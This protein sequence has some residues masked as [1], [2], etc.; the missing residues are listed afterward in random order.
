M[1]IPDR[2]DRR[3]AMRLTARASGAAVLGAGLPGL[4]AAC[5][6][7]IK[8]A[9]RT[10]Y[11]LEYADVD[12]AVAGPPLGDLLRLVTARAK[13]KG[14]QPVLTSGSGFPGATPPEDLRLYTKSQYQVDPAT[15]QHPPATGVAVA[16]PFAPAAIGPVAADA[17]RRG[18]KL[19]SYLVGFTPHTATIA[20]DPDRLGALLGEHAAA[21]AHQRLGGRGSVVLVE[22]TPDG[23]FSNGGFS[24]TVPSSLRALRR[25]LAQ[26]APG[27]EVVATRQAHA[28]ITARQELPKLL[29]AHPD[30]RMV[31]AWSDDTAVG[32]ARALRAARPGDR[33]GFYV[34]GL[35]I[36]ALKGRSTLDELRRGDVLRALAAVRPSDL[37]DALVDLPHA[38]LQGDSPKDIMI[39]PQILTPG[40]AALAA[41]AADY[42]ADPAAH[43]PELGARAGTNLNPLDSDA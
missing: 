4:L 7:T 25:T 26:R 9:G 30:V 8:P 15:G 24:L 27:L 21:W 17:V 42:S 13:A 29:A 28:A 6:K 16:G 40:S 33:T 10:D 18:V 37:A 43:V 11:I 31:L 1:S 3:T 41:H 38:L 22:P 5:G 23:P 2:F 14:V 12:N 36:P 20:V 32:A 39:V 19:V 34:G 35:G